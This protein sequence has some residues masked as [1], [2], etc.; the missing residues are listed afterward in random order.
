M[1]NNIVNLVLLFLITQHVCAQRGFIDA[2]ITPIQKESLYREKAFIH[3][4]KTKFFI[5]QSIWFTFYI[6][7][8]HNNYPSNYTTNFNVNLLDEQGNVIMSKVFLTENGIGFGDFL[9][10]ENL[11]IG[12]YY[13]QGFTNYMKNFGTK[14]YYL[15]EIEIINFDS[16]ISSNKFSEELVDIQLFPESGYLL[17]DIENTIGIKVLVNGKGKMFNGKILNSKG[18]EISNFIG[19]RFG[20]TKAQFFYSKD[21]TYSVA[22]NIDGEIKIKEIPKATPTG[23]IFSVDNLGELFKIS[24]KTNEKTLPTLNDDDLNLLIYRNN[25]ISDAFSFSFDNEPLQEFYLEKTKMLYGVNIVTLFKNKIPIAERKLFVFKQNEETAILIDKDKETQDSVLVKIK[26]T[27]SEN[28]PISTNLSISILPKD[29]K[30]YDDYQN[31]KSAFL[32]S[33]YVMGTIENPSYYLKNQNSNNI[34]DLDLL[35]LNQGWLKYSLAEKIVEL[36][37]KEKFQFESGFNLNG[38]LNNNKKLEVG[39]LSSSNRIL[40]RS[41]ISNTG[42][43]T[44]KNILVFKNQKIKFALIDKNNHLEKPKNISLKTSTNENE[45]YK[46]LLPK[47]YANNTLIKETKAFIS[48]FE[49]RIE[50]DEISIKGNNR[51]T[52]FKPPENLAEN[53]STIG[54]LFYK[55]IK[56][57]EDMTLSGET[58]FSYFSNKG[59][60]RSNYFSFGRGPVT[61]GFSGATTN[62]DYTF[63]PEIYIDDLVTEAGTDVNILR[64]YPMSTVD[65]ILINKSG[66]GSV[67]GTGGTIR[68]YLKD[69]NHNVEKKDNFVELIVSTGFDRA[70]DYYR[71]SNNVSNENIFNLTEIDWI[72]SIKTDKEGQHYFKVSKNNFSNDYIFIVNGFSENGLLFYNNSSFNKS[73]L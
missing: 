36:S 29:S 45:N 28:K 71:P 35:L 63:P 17:E 60:I 53:H 26:T 50:L 54:A 13:I 56:V 3:L 72:S 46:Y 59:Y 18:L 9:L 34:Y 4:N 44:F 58:L 5:G 69:G 30:I 67:K 10:D 16:K 48:S 42:T 22:L 52:T 65:E 23:V 19:N 43:F 6:G 25:Y 21:E 40:S 70:I 14:N 55:G 7:K 61:F 31:I 57:K 15:Q 47:A 32:L 37:P 1:K 27:N 49:D 62:L 73:K 68:I 12:K 24:I 64:Q 8:D 38:K 66:G 2:V 39:I 11:K 33:P 51:K 41:S 20:M